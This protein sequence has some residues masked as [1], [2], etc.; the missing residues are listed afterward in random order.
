MS[1]ELGGGAGAFD[2]LGETL[3]Q[4]HGSVSIQHGDMQTVGGC[5]NNPTRRNPGG[6]FDSREG[7]GGLHSE[8]TLEGGMGRG[9]LKQQ[10]GTSGPAGHHGGL[11]SRD[12]ETPTA[13]VITAGNAVGIELGDLGVLG[14]NGHSTGHG[15]GSCTNGGNENSGGGVGVGRMR[16]AD[17]SG[18]ITILGLQWRVLIPPQSKRL[19]KHLSALLV[20]LWACWVMASTVQSTS[21]RLTNLAFVTFTLALS[22]TL[23]LLIVLADVVGGPGVKVAT[24]ENF[25]SWQLTI[26]MIANVFTGVVNMS[27]RTIYARPTVAFFVLI[28]YAFVVT[29]IVWILSKFR[30]H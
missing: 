19:V 14:V 6:S 29:G 24:I 25:N 7:M 2:Q 22:M 4:K 1:G 10:L 28:G 15:P 26:F 21:R 11:D 12:R 13:S 3:G 30:P 8:H 18:A 17:K 27:M 20:L 23:I 16:P 5:S 9:S